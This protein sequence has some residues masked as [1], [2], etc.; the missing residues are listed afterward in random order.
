MA[1]YLSDVNVK[2]KGG[3]KLKQSENKALNYQNKFKYRK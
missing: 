3:S 1:W 2:R